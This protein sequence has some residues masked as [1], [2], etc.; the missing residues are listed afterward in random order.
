M[1]RVD[2]FD[3][4]HMACTVILALSPAVPLWLNQRNI[5]KE[6]DIV[7]T[8]AAKCQEEREQHE[9]LLRQQLPSDPQIIAKLAAEL[10]ALGV[11]TTMRDICIVILNKDRESKKII[12][13]NGQ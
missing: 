2:W 12:A 6:L 5:R 7:K 4:F 3:A 13:A 10:K 11:P 9:A 1:H 8:E